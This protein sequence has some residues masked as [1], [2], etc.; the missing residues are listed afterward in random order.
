MGEGKNPIGQVNAEGKKL[1]GCHDDKIPLL[2]D[3]RYRN[4]SEDLRLD[5][6]SANQLESHDTGKHAATRKRKRE[7]KAEA[8]AGATVQVG[9][10]DGE[11]NA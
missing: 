10:E 2:Q 4:F 5:T 3:G 6:L 11:S 1:V 9:A 8:E 7:E